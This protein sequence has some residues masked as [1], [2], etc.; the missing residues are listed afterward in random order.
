[1]EAMKFSADPHFAPYVQQHLDDEDVEIRRQ[2]IL[3]AAALGMRA[4]L[5]RLRK[6]FSDPRVRKEALVAYAT[7]APVGEA[8]FEVRRLVGKIEQM[9]GG[10]SNEEASLLWLALNQRFVGFGQGPL[11]DLAEEEDEGRQ[12][13]RGTAK[14]G[15]NDPCPCGSGKKFKKCC[16][17]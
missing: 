17:A 8:R 11:A 1:L 14:V 5:G 6:H 15:R 2:A 16:G 9:A 10:L 4:E 3:A 7:L 12:R 13:G